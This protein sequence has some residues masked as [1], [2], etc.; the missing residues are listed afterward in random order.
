MFQALSYYLN[1]VLLISVL[2]IFIVYD[3]GGHI[4]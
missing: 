1:H 3:L 4:Y 2:I